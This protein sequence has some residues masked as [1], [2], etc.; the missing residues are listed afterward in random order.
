MLII[1][2]LIFVFDISVTGHF[3]C[4]PFTTDKLQTYDIE[5]INSLKTIFPK[6]HSSQQSVFTHSKIAY[7]LYMLY[8]P[9][10]WSLQY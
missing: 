9:L 6:Q 10:N 1:K 3:R 2:F 5:S 7:S 4:W 8:L